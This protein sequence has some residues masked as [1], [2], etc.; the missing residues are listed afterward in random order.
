MIQKTTARET[1][2]P[3]K[4]GIL[5]LNYNGLRYL[6]MFFE[7]AGFLQKNPEA[8]LILIDNASVDESINWMQTH[9]PWVKVIRNSENFGFSEGYNQGILKL[10][11]L[12]CDYTHYMFLNNDVIVSQAWLNTMIGAIKLSEPDVVEF[13]CRSV[14]MAPYIRETLLTCESKKFASLRCDITSHPA[15]SERYLH[16]RSRTLEVAS[17]IMPGLPPSLDLTQ[18]GDTAEFSAYYSIELSTKSFSPLLFKLADGLAWNCGN[19]DDI[20]TDL[21]VWKSAQTKIREP[22]AIA[23]GQLIKL[24]RLL[25][26]AE[27]ASLPPLIQNSGIGLTKS[28]EGFDLHCFSAIDTP[29]DVGAAR[30][31]CG[32]CKAIRSDVFDDL[33]GFDNNIFMY[34]EDLDLSLRLQEKGYKSRMVEE[35]ILIHDHSGSSNNHSAFFKRQVVWSLFYFHWRHGSLVRRLI[36]WL[37]YKVLAHGERNSYVNPLRRHHELAFSKFKSITS[38]S[39]LL[40]G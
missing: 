6:P 5:L 37:R 10:K 27:L 22:L 9:A 36:T 8:E 25:T 19:L 35:A 13:G 34:Y 28:L 16:R 31:I 14:F 38:S 23:P 30:G 40:G 2:A 24:R 7:H 26:K 1:Q 21:V 15:S 11:D 33:G 3:I 4:I 20:V 18:I 17:K 12:G 39:Y 29:Q 32:V